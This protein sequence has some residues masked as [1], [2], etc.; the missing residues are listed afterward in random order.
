MAKRILLGMQKHQLVGVSAL[1]C[2]CV[3]ESFGEAAGSDLALLLVVLALEASPP[4]D[5]SFGVP[6]RETRL[7]AL[8]RL[9]NSCPC[10]LLKRFLL[11]EWLPNQHALVDGA[12]RY[13][14]PD[15]TH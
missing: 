6:E 3:A 13:K 10:V 14:P 8:A 7:P 4:C 1:H 2:L 12:S 11:V 5:D 9:T 15:Q